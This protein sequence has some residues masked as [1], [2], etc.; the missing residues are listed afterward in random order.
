MKPLEYYHKVIKN[1]IELL[2]KKRA[3]WRK[4]YDNK[5]NKEILEIEKE[6]KIKNELRNDLEKEIGYKPIILR[7]D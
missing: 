2:E 4:W 7:F 1:D 6:L 3:S 5:K